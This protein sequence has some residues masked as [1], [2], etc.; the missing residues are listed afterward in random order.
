MPAGARIVREELFGPVLA[1]AGY[2]DEPQAIRLANDSPYGLAAGV[3]TS[4]MNAA[5]RLT[6]ALHAGTVWV[7]TC[8]R[9]PLAT[10][11]GGFKQSGSGRDRS[12][13]ALDTYCDLKTIWTAYT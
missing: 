13:H 11:F 10:P 5:H 2:Q 7:N 8:E 4:D 6:G 3:W 9:S 12:P 1:V